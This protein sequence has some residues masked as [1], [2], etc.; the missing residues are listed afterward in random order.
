M[1][2]IDRQPA[3]TSC[4]DALKKK[5]SFQQTKSIYNMRKKNV[6]Q[7]HIVLQGLEQDTRCFKIS[8][9]GEKKN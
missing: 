7:G 3:V 8:I 6:D 2:L 5:M 1:S 4:G 9:K